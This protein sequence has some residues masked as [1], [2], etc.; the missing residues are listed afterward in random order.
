MLEHVSPELPEQSLNRITLPP[1]KSDVKRARSYHPSI[2]IK[3]VC[4]PKANEVPRLPLSS[5]RLNRLQ[6]EV[7]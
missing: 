1:R 6:I 5:R 3:G 7:G 2:D 4:D